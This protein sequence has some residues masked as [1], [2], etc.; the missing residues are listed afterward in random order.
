M[1]MIIEMI[2]MIIRNNLRKHEDEDDC[3]GAPSKLENL[4]LVWPQNLLLVRFRVGRSWIFIIT[5]VQEGKKGAFGGDKL[6]RVGRKVETQFDEMKVQTTQL[7]STVVWIKMA[8]V[9]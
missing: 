9:K 7:L 5:K 1:E 8:S 2:M 3:E 4:R 6:E